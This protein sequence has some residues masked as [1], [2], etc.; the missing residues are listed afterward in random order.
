MQLIDIPQDQIKGTTENYK[1]WS[2]LEIVREM[3]EDFLN[4]SDDFLQQR[5]ND[6]SRIANYEL[7]D[8]SQLQFTSFERQFIPEKLF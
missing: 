1:L 3:K 6:T 4:V 5:A 8:G 2:Q 7:P